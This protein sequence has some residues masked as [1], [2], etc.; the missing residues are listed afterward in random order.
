MSSVITDEVIPG[1]L[2]L[3]TYPIGILQLC[4]EYFYFLFKHSYF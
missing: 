1:C 4:T 2:I 3:D